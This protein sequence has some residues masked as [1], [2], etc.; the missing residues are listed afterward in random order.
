MENKLM[1]NVSKIYLLNSAGV[2]RFGYFFV[3][4]YIRVK[5]NFN[6]QL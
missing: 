4:F 5:K 2:I 3:F 1:S 6:I